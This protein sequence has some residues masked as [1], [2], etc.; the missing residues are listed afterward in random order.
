MPTDDTK[1]QILNDHYKDSFTHLR[2]YLKLR[3]WLFFLILIVMTLMSFQLYSPRESREVI[4]QFLMTIPSP[5][6]PYLKGLLS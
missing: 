6:S 1:L 3:D 2:D 4:Y 5:K